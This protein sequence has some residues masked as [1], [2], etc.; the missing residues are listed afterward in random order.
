MPQKI[1]LVGAGIKGWEGFGSKALEV[2]GKAEVLIGHQRLLDIFPDFAG[3][4]RVLEDFSDHA[5]VPE[6]HRE[7]G[8][9]ARLR[10]P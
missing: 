9:R 6:E 7:A 3:E 8:G 10:R 2:I 1:Y 5:G 4:K